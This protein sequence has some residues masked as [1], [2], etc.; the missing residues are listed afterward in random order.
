MPVGSLIHAAAQAHCSFLAL[1]SSGLLVSS[2]VYSLPLSAVDCPSEQSSGDGASFSMF[3]YVSMWS[4]AIESS[5][6]VWSSVINVLFHKNKEN[7]RIHLI[8]K[9]TV[10]F[11]K[12]KFSDL[13]SSRELHKS[14]YNFL[15]FDAI[16]TNSICS[17]FSL[18]KVHMNYQLS[19][20]GFLQDVTGHC[21]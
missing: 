7:P 14:C 1:F 18:L 2:P 4:V 5:L 9:S 3:A 15:P 17:L 11:V 21:W 20:P 8:K 16:V 19:H 10:H 6:S 13:Y 12:Q